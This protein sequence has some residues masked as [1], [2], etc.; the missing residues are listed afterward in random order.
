MMGGSELRVKRGMAGVKRGEGTEWRRRPICPTTSRC[1]LPCPI[2]PWLRPHRPD[3][4][5]VGHPLALGQRRLFGDP[6]SMKGC[7]RITPTVLCRL[8][9]QR[10][11]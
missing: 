3:R 4:H 11:L 10:H 2:A 5:D 1:S 8:V 6:A 7:I 9:G